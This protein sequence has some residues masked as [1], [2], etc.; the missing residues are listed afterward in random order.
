MRENPI[1]HSRLDKVKVN[2]KVRQLRLCV[3]HVNDIYHGVYL[4]NK[5]CHFTLTLSEQ[6]EQKNDELHGF[7]IAGLTQTAS[8]PCS[9][10]RP[11][12]I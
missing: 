12:H 11:E 5:R 10:G 8:V 7:P 3:N 2:E 9:T 4:S 6:S 1:R